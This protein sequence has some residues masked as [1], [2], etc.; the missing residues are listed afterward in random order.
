MLGF[1]VVLV[2][3]CSKNQQCHSI[4]SPDLVR[5]YPRIA[6]GIETELWQE[7]TRAAHI[8]QSQGLRQSEVKG[9]SHVCGGST[10]FGRFSS[11]MKRRDIE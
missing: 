8:S 5:R 9:W 6:Q 10:R 2:L 7:S 4:S 11:S 1:A 3:S